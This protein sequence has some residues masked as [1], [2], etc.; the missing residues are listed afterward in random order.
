MT[1]ASALVVL[2][3]HAGGFYMGDPSM[4]EPACETPRAAGLECVAVDYPL[5]DMPAAIRKA[6]RAARRYDGRVLAYGESAGGILAARLA[7]DGKAIAAATVASPMDLAH[8]EH[9][10]DPDLWRKAGA[11]MKDRRRWA[12]TDAPDNPIRLHDSQ[13][14]P[15]VPWCFNADFV[16][17]PR[18]T[19][20]RAYGY[21]S[22][23]DLEV[24]KRAMAWLLKKG[25]RR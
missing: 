12:M 17:R 19:R 15:I 8:Y 4:I 20:R 10:N 21:H 23:I 22:H 11:T 3:F 5:G 2:A 1:A 7:Y 6:R 25:G 9:P 14:D 13:E 18:V 24:R 16:A